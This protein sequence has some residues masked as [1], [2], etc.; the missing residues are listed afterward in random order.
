MPIKDW[1]PD[2]RPREKLQQKG[3]EALSNSELI[4][5]LIQSGRK[6]LPA[7]EIA[8]KILQLGDNDLAK[9]GQLSFQ[10]LKTVEGVGKARAVLVA[11]AL[12][13]G[14]RRQS[15]DLLTLKKRLNGSKA[16]VDMLQ[17]LLLDHP[18]EIF[19][20]VFL[21]SALVPVKVE[22]LSKG[23]IDRAIVDVR[24]LLRKAL[25]THAVGIILC[26]NHPSGALQPSK[27]DLET[28]AN[29]RKAAQCLDIRLLDHV[30]VS[31]QG[32]FSF[33]DQGLLGE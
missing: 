23:G 3:P 13:L 17:P 9:L 18:Y 21:N 30:I 28:T 26:H 6:G 15:V 2:D 31:S 11:A 4:A 12:E 22:P 29:V 27:A 16:V 7:T 20:A 14:R 32:Y 10:Q 8:K 19:I 25:E 24:V 33:A 5:I 1:A